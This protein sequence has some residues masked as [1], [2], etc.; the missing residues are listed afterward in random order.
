MTREEHLKFCEICNNQKFDSQKGIICGLR[1]SIA[2][3]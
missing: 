2:D 3:F 1:N